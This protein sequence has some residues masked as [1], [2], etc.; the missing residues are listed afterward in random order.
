[1]YEHVWI[2]IKQ[3]V[4][5]SW[6]SEDRASW[7]I[8]KSQRDTL[9]FKFIV[10]KNSTC[11]GQIYSPSSAVSTLYAVIGICHASYVDCLLARSS[12]A[13]RWLLL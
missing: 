2:V 8:L 11:F 1:M 3:H 6:H 7:Y 12:F 10:V 9:F 4:Y 5:Q 13:P